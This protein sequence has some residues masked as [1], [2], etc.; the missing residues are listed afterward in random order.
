MTVC[1]AALADV[2]KSVV[3][4]CDTMLSGSDFSGDKVAFKLYPLSDRFHWWAMV[5]GDDITHIV[6]IIEAATL[7]LLGLSG[8]SNDRAT[9]ERAVVAA[10]QD[11]RTR[12]A[13]DLVLAPIGMTMETWRSCPEW[14]GHLVEKLEGVDL[15]CQL[16]VAGFDWVGDGHIFTVEN[17]GVAKNHDFAGW[18]SIGS[19]AYSA[20]GTLLYHSVNYEMQLARV[21]YHVCE[22]KFMAE[23]APGVGKHTVV[24]ILNSTM[25]VKQPSELSE[26]FIAKIRNDWER[27]GR[28]RVPTGTLAGIQMLLKNGSFG[29][30]TQ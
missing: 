17:P 30:S 9:V 16:L 24:K 29:E 10:Y 18:A 23:S 5:S 27:E 1:I 14:Q 19:G 21:L 13:E 20:I 3:M 6:P 2:G 12:Y 22:A 15:G 4:A 11:V 7:N 8:S 25:P 26:D 28:P